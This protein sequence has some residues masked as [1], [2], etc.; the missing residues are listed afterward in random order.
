LLSFGIL[1]VGPPRAAK[2]TAQKPAPRPFAREVG[3]T[4][5]AV[6]VG[7]VGVRRGNV[8]A[9][10]RLGYVARAE[11]AAGPLEGPDVGKLALVVFAVVVAELVGDAVEEGRGGSGGL[12]LA[13]G[14]A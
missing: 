10:G 7:A 3:V 5:R 8:V 11:G 2:G 14:E 6:S 4:V 9:L 12:G 13:K 1:A